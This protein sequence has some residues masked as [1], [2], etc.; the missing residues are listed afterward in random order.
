MVQILLGGLKEL[1][2]S[3]YH[4]LIVD[5]KN[6]Q[7]EKDLLKIIQHIDSNKKK[8]RL[9]EVDVEKLE[10]IGLRK[11]EE[12]VSERNYMARNRKN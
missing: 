3:V 9:D 11:Y 7:S 8:L 6:C 5:I 4:E 12:M 2:M 10:A 1:K